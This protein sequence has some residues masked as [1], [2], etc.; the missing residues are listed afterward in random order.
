MANSGRILIGQLSTSHTRGIMKKSSYLFTLS[1]IILLFAA[2]S[3][4]PT[5]VPVPDTPEP[6]PELIEAAPTDNPDTEETVVENA[7]FEIEQ[8]KRQAERIHLSPL[9]Q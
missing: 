5:A 8:T 2:C 4:K 3:S 6:T 9:Y 1:V 7:V